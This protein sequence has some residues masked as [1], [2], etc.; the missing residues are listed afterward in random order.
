MYELMNGLQVREV[1][2]L[3]EMDG[4]YIFNTPEF[5]S[6]IKG[7]AR[8]FTLTKNERI[9]ARIYFR[10]EKNQATSGYQAPFGSIDT[11]RSLPGATIKYFLEQVCLTLKND[12]LK[13]VI[14][15]HWPECFAT[16]DSLQESFSQLGFKVINSEVNQHIVVQES[17]FRLLIRKN[18][19]K[20]LN[21]CLKK[22]FTFSILTLADLPQVYQLVTKTRERKSYPVSMTYDQLYKTMKLLSDSY[23]LFGLLDEDKLIAA[24]VSI[25]VSPHIL[26]NF[27]HADEFSYRSTSPLVMLLQ[28]IYQY[29]QQNGIKIL[30]LGISS[31]NGQIN[32]GLFNFKE[33]LG[34]ATS[35]KNTYSLIY[36]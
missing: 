22:N 11:T 24:S 26:Y 27:Y 1:T 34:C 10:I 7:E 18:E 28:E 19:R 15:K 13:E 2:Q 21:Q 31:E 32:Q 6:L 29:C 36:D 30:D 4:G 16:S 5:L 8:Y 20:K 14:V 35:T 3:P 17:E 25:R 12:R 23:L 33:N 9:I